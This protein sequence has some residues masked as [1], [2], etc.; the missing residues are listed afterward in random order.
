MISVSIYKYLNAELNEAWRDGEGLILGI[1]RALIPFLPT[2]LQLVG[3]SP[4]LMRVDWGTISQ[5]LE[6]YFM[7]DP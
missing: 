4:L 7:T 5:S 6:K 3:R 1:A 2:L